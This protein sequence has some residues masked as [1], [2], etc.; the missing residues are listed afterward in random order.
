MIYSNSAMMK[1]IMW[2]VVNRF[3]FHMPNSLVMSYLNFREVLFNRSQKFPTIVF[4]RHCFKESQLHFFV[5]YDKSYHQFCDH[6]YVILQMHSMF[7]FLGFIIAFIIIFNVNNVIGIPM[8]S[9]EGDSAKSLQSRRTISKPRVPIIEPADVDGR[10]SGRTA[11]IT[12]E[13]SGKSFQNLSSSGSGFSRR[14]RRRCIEKK[15]DAL[16]RWY[17]SKARQIY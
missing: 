10:K 14:R 12:D 1:R 3:T 17:C 16:G 4:S 8:L 7:N 11:M 13:V 15:R 9:Q 6:L 5:D 2:L